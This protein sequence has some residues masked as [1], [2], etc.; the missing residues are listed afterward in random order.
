MRMICWALVEISRI[1]GCCG[2]LYMACLLLK[3]GLSEITVTL[4]IF[5]AGTALCFGGHNYKETKVCPH[6]GKIINGER[7]DGTDVNTKIH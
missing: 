6:C 2:I 3:D 1:T 5:I 4:L 7:K